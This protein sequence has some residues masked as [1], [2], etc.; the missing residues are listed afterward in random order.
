MLKE[1]VALPIQTTLQIANN[2]Q[3]PAPVVSRVVDNAGAATRPQV[4][5]F[6]LLAAVNLE[7]RDVVT[8]RGANM[9]TAAVGV[10][11]L[12]ALAPG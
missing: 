2:A 7:H 5:V 9:F 8:R 4:A 1:D 11:V 6:Q 12:N 10:S 3:V